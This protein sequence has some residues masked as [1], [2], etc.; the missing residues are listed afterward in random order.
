MAARIAK[1]LTNV[2]NRGVK[3]TKVNGPTA[4]KYFRA[5]MMPPSPAELPQFIRE[6][7]QAAGRVASLSVKNMTVYEALIST[8][9]FVE[10]SMWFFLGEMIGKRS[11]CGYQ[12][13]H[14]Y[15]H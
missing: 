1:H 5:E 2:A 13:P 12:V 11:I 7:G 14:T 3:Y 8:A 10:V 9:V 6:A 15:A 4:L